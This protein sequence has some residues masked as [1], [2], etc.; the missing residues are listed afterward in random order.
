MSTIIASKISESL[1]GLAPI[2]GRTPHTPPEEAD[3]A[4]ATLAE[5]DRTGIYAGSFDGESAWERHLN[6]DELVQ[7]LAG[8]TKL[9]ILTET[10]RTDLEMSQGMVTIVPRGCWHKFSAPD[11]VTVLTMT[12]GP[13]DH[14][15]ADD[16]RK[17]A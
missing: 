10:G 2:A 3:P 1:E 4:F 9:S 12:P 7:V 15:T 11:G 14:S 8:A 5:T 13:T 17:E 6:G 16:P